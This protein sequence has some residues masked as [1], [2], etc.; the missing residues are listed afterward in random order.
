MM[1]VRLYGNLTEDEKTAL[2]V[3]GIP[4]GWPAEVAYADAQQPVPAG[5]VVFTAEELEDQK[6]LHLAEY[7]AWIESC[8]VA[9]PD[10]TDDTITIQATISNGNFLTI[11]SRAP[12]RGSYAVFFNAS[13]VVKSIKYGIYLDDVSIVDSERDASF[14]KLTPTILAAQADLYVLDGQTI[15]VRL[16]SLDGSPVTVTKRS[17]VLIQKDG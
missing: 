3:I 15:S 17:I 16:T 8:I 7:T 12:R 11:M 9:P 14:S 6:A 5:W 10:P 1:L 13:A 4:D 2:N